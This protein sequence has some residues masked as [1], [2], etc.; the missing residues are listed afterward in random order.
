MVICKK[1]NLKN[2]CSYLMLLQRFP[3]T[4]WKVLSM[5]Y[6]NFH[7]LI[8]VLLASF[9]SYHI[10]PS[11]F[12][13][14]R[15]QTILTAPIYSMLFLRPVPL[16]MLSS[17]LGMLLLLLLVCLPPPASQTSNGLLQEPVLNTPPRS[18]TSPSW[19]ALCSPVTLCVCLYQQLSHRS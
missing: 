9:T 5:A 13:L 7:N 19:L 8:S 2:K 3:V 1:A 4:H 6:R 18:P 16:L 10:P 17:L 15:Y 11:N 14:P 12:T